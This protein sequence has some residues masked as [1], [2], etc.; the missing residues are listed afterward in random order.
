MRKIKAQ[1]IKDLIRDAAE[2]QGK[3]FNL[4][5]YRRAKKLYNKMPRTIRHKIGGVNVVFE[6]TKNP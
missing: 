5:G 2:K 4:S 6:E 1:A 3:E